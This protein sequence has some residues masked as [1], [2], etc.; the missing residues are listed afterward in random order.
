MRNHRASERSGERRP[1]PA[2]RVE[3][4]GRTEPA[5]RP[6]P[7]GRAG[8]GGGPATALAWAAAS[9]LLLPACIAPGRRETRVEPPPRAPR[10][11]AEATDAAARAPSRGGDAIVVA[12]RRVPIGTRVVLWTDP[13]GYDATSTAPRFGPVGP[14]GPQGLRYRP[15]RGGDPR[16]VVDL[17]VVHYDVCG[18]SEKC[19]EV[20]HDRRGLSVH[21][22]L[23]VD[24]TIYQTLDV[25]E[26]AWHASEQ[27]GRSVGVEV[28]HIGAYPPGAPS[29]LDTWYV[30]DAE[31]VRMRFPASYGDGGVRTPGFV[32]RPRRP[33]PVRGVVQGQRL[34]QY[35]F[36]VQQY[37]ALARLA[38]GLSVA[39]PRIELRVPLGP[40]GQVRDAALPADELSSFSGVV[41]HWHTST[42]KTDPGPAFDWDRFLVRARASRAALAAPRP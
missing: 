16:E 27:N 23:D 25:A 14:D 30:R 29:P 6:A 8:R 21:F 13:G 18:T 37:D 26:T 33:E 3:R 38:A 11:A 39:L 35:D 1:E 34:E 4:T 7:A 31:G 2:R 41:G 10:P 40:D 22:L 20:L 24:G 42:A 12:G 28:A 15:G 5:I 19:F 36:T 17:F 32:P 9:I